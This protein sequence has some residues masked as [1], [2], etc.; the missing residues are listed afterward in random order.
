M[1]TDVSTLLETFNGLTEVPFLSE[2]A[3][4]EE[5]TIRCLIGVGAK[6]SHDDLGVKHIV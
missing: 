4:D 3:S 2:I 5:V 1:T 6:E